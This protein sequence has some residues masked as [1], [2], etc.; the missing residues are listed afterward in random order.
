MQVILIHGMGRTAL[1]MLRLGRA[2]RRAGHP[3]HLFGYVAAVEPFAR[4]ADRARR[5]CARLGA[6][7]PYAIVGHS[8]GGLLARVALAGAPAS[9]PLPRHLM[10]LGTPHHPPRQA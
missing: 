8:L 3:V 2:I 7:G 5:E 4:I 1:S 6:R 10:M 9:F